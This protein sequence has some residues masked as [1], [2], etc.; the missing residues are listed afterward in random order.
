MTVAE[1]IAASMGSDW[2]PTVYEEKVRSLRTRSY[3]FD[4]PE[5]ENTAEIQH[6]L[7]GIELKVGKHRMACPDLSTAR[8]LR[9]FARLG[10][11]SVAVPYD[12]SVIPGLADELESSWQRTLLR[13]VER[14]KGDSQAVRSRVRSLVVKEIR[15]EVAKIGAGEKMPLFKTSTKQ[16]K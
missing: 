1:E 2:L 8:Y 7:L 16:R 6:T 11:R 9:V 14:T 4:V 12:V 10:C 5:R 13:I 3:D 15:E